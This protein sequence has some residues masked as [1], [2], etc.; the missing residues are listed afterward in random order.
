MGGGA[1]GGASA[2]G[3]G[4]LAQPAT[5]NTAAIATSLNLFGILIM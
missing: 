4:L 2:A 3:F 5:T 1:G